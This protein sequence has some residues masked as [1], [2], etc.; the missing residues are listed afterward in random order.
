M[1]NENDVCLGNGCP[2]D[3]WVRVWVLVIV[4]GPFET[5]TLTPNPCGIAGLGFEFQRDQKL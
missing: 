2:R 1:R 3:F 4:S 5:Q